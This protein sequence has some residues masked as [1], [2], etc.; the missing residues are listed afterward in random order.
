MDHSDYKEYSL[1]ELRDPLQRGMIE[2][3]IKELRNEGD[4]S[5]L[6]G[7]SGWL[8]LPAIMLVLGIVFGVI[9]LLFGISIFA[10]VINAGYGG[11]YALEIIVTGALLV[12]TIYATKLFFQKKRNA[13]E[14]IINLFIA[15]FF[16]SGGLFLVESFI[17]ADAFAK[18]N[19]MQLP[20][21]V[22][23]AIIL[24]PYFLVS[25]RVKAT[26]VN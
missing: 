14:V 1:N 19:F 20:G 12:L 18:D 9:N 16:A 25:N 4:F 10:D 24:I 6:E 22:L 21:N 11:V 7:I 8:I 5:E 26:F 3:R 13:P 17:G 23:S 15:S 2:R